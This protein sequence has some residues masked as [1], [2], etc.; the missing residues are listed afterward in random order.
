MTFLHFEGVAPR[1]Y[2]NL[3]RQHGER[4][5]CGIAVKEADDLEKV[6]PEYLDDYQAFEAKVVDHLTQL[7]GA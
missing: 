1:Q 7:I 5:D 6:V 3:F 2:L 4:K